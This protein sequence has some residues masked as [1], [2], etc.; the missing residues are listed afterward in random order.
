MRPKG[1][2]S[3]RKCVMDKCHNLRY[4]DQLLCHNHY[5]IKDTLYTYRYQSEVLK[6]TNMR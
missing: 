3:D 4:Q 2:K 1:K 5:R 6:I